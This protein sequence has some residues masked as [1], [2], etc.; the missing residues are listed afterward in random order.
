MKPIICRILSGFIFDK[1]KRKAFRKKYINKNKEDSIFYI[2]P[3]PILGTDF[4]GHHLDKKQVLVLG[5]YGHFNCGDEI[6]LKSTLKMIDKN[7]EVSVMFVPTYRYNFEQWKGVHCYYPPVD[8]FNIENIVN[9]YD[10]LIIG[11]ELILMML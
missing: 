6:M 2:Y 4:S 7:A 11:G 5:Y 3:K 8:F 9:F 1:Q 10:E